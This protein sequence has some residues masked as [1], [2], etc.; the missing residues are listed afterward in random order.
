[1]MRDSTCDAYQLVDGVNPGLM[2]I[3]TT[4][5]SKIK[6]HKSFNVILFFKYIF[7]KLL[8]VKSDSLVSNI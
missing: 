6:I 4:M 3:F 7:I 8:N 2:M 5:Y 1:M